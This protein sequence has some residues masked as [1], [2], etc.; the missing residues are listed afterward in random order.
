MPGFTVD[1]VKP[2]RKLNVEKLA[3]IKIHEVIGDV[4]ACTGCSLQGTPHPLPR[5]GSAPQFMVV[6]DS[7]HWREERAGKMLEG[8]PAEVVKAGLK[9]V[10]LKVADGYYTSLV[11]A[12]KP[13]EQKV[14][15]NEQINGCA[16]WLQK[17]IEILRPPVIIAMGSNAIR[18]FSP[19][20]KGTPSDLAGKVIYR[21]DLDATIIFGLNPG[22]L[23]HDPSK[24]R[25]VEGI[26][27][28]LAEVL[29]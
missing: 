17:E 16:G 11:K 28:K 26:F 8:E 23:F 6:F 1:M 7:P 5:M 14:L 13:K 3:Q 4:A 9:G 21:K 19:G 27:N 29:S 24:L 20:L 22:S 15:T 25:V 12:S 18:H 2:D 10:G